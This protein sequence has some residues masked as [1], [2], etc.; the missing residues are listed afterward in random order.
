MRNGFQI[1]DTHTHLGEARHTGRV[2]TVDTLLATMDRCG[3]DRSLLIPFPVV[4]D[5]RAQHDRIADAIRAYSD[6]FSGA[7]CIDPFISHSEFRDEVRRC[8][9]E[10]GFRALK[11]QPQY[12]P[13]NP[14]S[15]RSDFFFESALENKLTVV[16]H[17]GAGIPY[18]LPSLFIMPA[19]KYPDLT[20]VLAHGGSSVYVTECLVAASVCEN[21]V[22]EL[23]SLMPHHITEVLRHVPSH[24]L[25]AGSDLPESLD[26]E[27]SKILGM[28]LPE[29]DTKNILWRTARRVIDGESD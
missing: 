13:L 7:A 16:A 4:A 11:L 14:I 29:E 27:M 22:I 12:Q 17:T 8:A 23:S 26:A 3:V 18:S 19:R 28:D 10:L 9:T 20:I 24:R 21:I 1:Y 15:E 2:A 25:M 5:Y 6:R